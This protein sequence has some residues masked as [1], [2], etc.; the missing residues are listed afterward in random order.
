MQKN[1]IQKFGVQLSLDI[2]EALVELRKT[3]IGHRDL[4]AE[5]IIIKRVNSEK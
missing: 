4:K 1:K 3:M 2:L 5:N